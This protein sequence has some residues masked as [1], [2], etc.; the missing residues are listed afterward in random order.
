M[1]FFSH[2]EGRVTSLFM[3]AVGVLTIVCPSDAA[4]HVKW[5]STFNVAATPR[6][7]GSVLS[8]NFAWL[9][10]VSAAALWAG[11]VLERT[12][13][14]FMLR[15]AFNALTSALQS[16][17]EALLRACAGAFFVSLWVLGNVILTPELKTS[18]VVLPWLQVAIAIGLF[19]QR[20]MILSGIGIIVLYAAGIAYYGPFHL[21][22][23]PIFLG[24]AG[25]FILTSLDRTIY[26]LRPLD[27]ARWGTAITLMWASIEKWA[28]PDW[29][30]PLLV[31]HPNLALGWDPRLYMTA[32]GM[33]EFVLAFGL[34]WTPLVRRLSALVLLAMFISA[35]FEFGKIDAIGHLMIIAILI[36]ILA[37]DPKVPTWRPVP[38]PILYALALGGTLTAYYGLHAI[39]FGAV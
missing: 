2:H 21:M 25:F 26:G 29:T 5:F 14:G 11:A 39:V 1:R 28:Y 27:V 8:L 19:W 10:L 6:P 32:A 30:Y 22:D 18:S 4:A 38:A 20:T 33:I 17:T 9:F 31:E 23:Y 37:D 36:C 35:V 34:I 7:L 3:S 15:D 12:R 16:R 24:L 13:F